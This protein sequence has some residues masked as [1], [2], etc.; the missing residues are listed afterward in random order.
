MYW[1]VQRTLELDPD[2]FV[3]GTQLDE[4]SSSASDADSLLYG[5]DPSEL[6]ELDA[7][8][9]SGSEADQNELTERDSYMSSIDPSRAAVISDGRDTRAD[10]KD[11]LYCG[12]AWWNVRLKRVCA[13][14]GASKSPIR[15]GG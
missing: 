12:G 9:E 15:K 6:L 1:T 4:D 8:D 2:T 7:V 10:P 11:L 3:T 13:E 14:I 5:D